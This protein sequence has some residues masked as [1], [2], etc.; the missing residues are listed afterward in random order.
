MRKKLIS[1]IVCVACCMSLIS[2]NSKNTQT[3]ISSDVSSASESP[4]PSAI[5]SEVQQILDQEEIRVCLI[6]NSLIDYG[7]Q[8]GY[9]DDI[10][11][12][13]GRNLFVD[14]ITWGGAWLEDYLDGTYMKKKDVKERLSA[15]DIVVFQ[16]YG[17]W[18]DEITFHAIKKLQKWCKEDASFYYYMYE[19]DNR[20][21]KASDYKKLKKQGLEMI[22]KGQLMD[23]LYEMGYSYEELHLEGDFHPNYFNGYV[24]ALLMHS[25]MFEEKCAEFPR[26]WLLG[27][28]TAYLSK[29]L[30]VAMEGF[31][32]KTEDEIWEEFGAICKKADELIDQTAADKN[33]YEKL[34]VRIELPES[35]KWIQNVKVSE[36]ADKEQVGGISYHDGIMNTDVTLLFWQDREKDISYVPEFKADST[37]ENGWSVV[38]GAEEIPITI[39]RAR[40]TDSNKEM[41]VLD[42]EYNGIVFYMYASLSYE[43]DYAS[44]AKVAAHLTEQWYELLEK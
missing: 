3:D 9:L 15:A 36:Y 12:S 42:W 13:Y 37:Q 8:P 28:Y 33:V 29:P 31:H 16:D 21:M 43:E 1:S 14:Q 32:S 24:S 35:E 6:G 22:P 5:P 44:I 17:G 27:E 4:S 18:Q 19:D 34:G 7:C 10:A 2:C 39:Q 25:V 40:A 11:L 26:E 38:L 30:D 20:E 41:V 23:A